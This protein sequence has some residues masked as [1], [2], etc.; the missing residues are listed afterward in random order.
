M[1][2]RKV[3]LNGQ[4]YRLVALVAR[5]INRGPVHE[6]LSKIYHD[7]PALEGL[8][9]KKYNP[10]ENEALYGAW[11]SADDPSQGGKSSLRYIL[12]YK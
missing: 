4:N 3:G 2:E 7:L 9:D 1:N 5:K 11:Q 8:A 6:G 10:P 12:R